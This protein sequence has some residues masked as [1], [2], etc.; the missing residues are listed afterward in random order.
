MVPYNKD[1]QLQPVFSQWAGGG[2]MNAAV[3]LD[4]GGNATFTN[5]DEISGKIVVRCS[6]SVDL[7]SIAVKL[8]GE[9]RTRLMS[10]GGV[11]GEK[12]RPQLEYHKIL[13][14]VQAV[15]PPPD[16]AEGRG[17]KA[18]YTIPAGEHEYPFRFKIPFNNSC[19]SDRSQVAAGISISGSGLELTKPPSHHV[20]KTLPPTLSGFP[21]EAE[22]RY[23]VKATVQ[24][25]SWWQ[26][27]TRTQTPFTFLP[28]EPPRPPPTG[29]EVYARQNHSFSVSETVPE[30]TRSWMKGRLGAKKEPVAVQATAEAPVVSVDARLPEPALLTCNQEIPLRIIVKRF[31]G[32]SHVIYLQSLQISL[33]ALTKIRA[34]DAHRTEATSWVIMSKSNMGVVI[35]SQADAAGVEAV[36]D[37]RLW[38]GVTLPNT[39]APS[40]ETCNI[41]R[42]Y[43]LDIKVGL[44][45]PAG[46]SE[47]QTVVL[48]LRLDTEVLSGI[49]PPAAL[50][51]AVALAK[52][53]P[54][55][56]SAMT[57]PV[58]DKLKTEGRMPAEFGAGQVPSTPMDEAGPSEPLEPPARHGMAGDAVPPAYMRE[59]PP[60]Y[61]DAVATNMPPVSAPRPDYAPP[62]S[63]DDDLLG[64][65]EKRGWVDHRQ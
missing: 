65:D 26:E 57:A 3:V 36:L 13:Y 25:N 24:R 64:R 40:F 18:A 59:A 6:K 27:N 60:S 35:G 44:S 55:R 48:P 5:L 43:Q 14:R 56:T 22:I 19:A 41:A 21:G 28:L 53:N 10:P 61:E 58:L 63:A 17:S 34:H 42:S 51:E 11:N 30:P 38:R 37:D 16:M 39:V 33:V 52:S 29:S 2:G 31:S 49:T 1:K 8:E 23:Y 4:Q 12:P 20:K 46:A 47:P 62:L 9:S 45:Y 32:C 15:F 54:R 7:S 50:L